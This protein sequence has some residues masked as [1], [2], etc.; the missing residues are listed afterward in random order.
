MSSKQN[1]IALEAKIIEVTSQ[2]Y[3]G[4]VKGSP[5]GVKYKIKLI[6]PGNQDDFL[7]IGCWI[8]NQYIDT[9]VY[10]GKFGSSKLAYNV[11]DT[12]I[13]MANFTKKQQIPDDEVASVQVKIKPEHWSQKV[14]LLYSLKNKEK[15][16]GFNEIRV[17]PDELRP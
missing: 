7:P 5:S 3:S 10:G 9:K 11:G 12:L 4:G 14:I 17:L 8:E 15:Y 16:A 1:G 13:L 2:K 6:T